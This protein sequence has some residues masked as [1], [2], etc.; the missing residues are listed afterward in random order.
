MYRPLGRGGSIVDFD[1]GADVMEDD[2]VFYDFNA[3]NDA[4]GVCDADPLF[5]F[6]ASR[7]IVK[8]SG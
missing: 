5:A 8:P 3:R 7:E 4:I 1:I 6:E 2:L